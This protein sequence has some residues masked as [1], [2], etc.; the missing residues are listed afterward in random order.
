MVRPSCSAPSILETVVGMLLAL[1]CGLGLPGNAVALW[2]FFRLEV[3]KPYTVYLLSL[4]LADLLLTVCL[5]FHAAFYL[6][7]RAWGLS[8]TSCQALLCLLLLSRGVGM[9]FLA[10]VACNRYL[11]VLHPRLKVILSPRMAWGISGLV[12]LLAALTHQSL[13]VSKAPQNSTEWPSFYPSTTGQEVL[14]FP[15]ILLPFGLISFCSASAIRTLQRRIRVSHKQPR[16]RQAKVLVTA[17]LLLLGLCFLPSVLTKVLMHIFRGSQ[18]CSA[19]VT[20][21]MAGAGSLTHLHSVLN[22]A[23]YFSNPAF[24]RSYRKVFSS[25]RGRRQAAGPPSSDLKDS[26]C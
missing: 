6:R 20:V 5:P 22:P 18:S 2:T 17:V 4:V 7:H 1:E 8:L 26:Y 25:L 23:V 10:A 24:T 12:A 11:C 19:A 21:H 14:F 9:A 13:L 15:Q 16:L 3:W